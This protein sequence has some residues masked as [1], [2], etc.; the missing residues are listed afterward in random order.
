M[1]QIERV[2][3]AI[4]IADNVDPDMEVCGMGVQLDAGVLAPAWKARIKQA[5][6]AIAA[7]H[8]PQ[9]AK[10]LRGELGR[11]PGLGMPPIKREGERDPDSDPA[12]R[13]EY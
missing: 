3:R 7:H 9:V 13:E 1:E 4:C 5:E 10:A 2:A 11:H 8:P 12:K 6:A